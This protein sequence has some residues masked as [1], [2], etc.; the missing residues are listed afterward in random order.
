MDIAFK[1]NSKAPYFLLSNFYGGSEFTYMS[2]RTENVNLKKL[3][4]KL[5]DNL[6][7]DTFKIYRERLMGKKIYKEGYKDAYVKTYNGKEYYGFGL[8]AKLIS[9]CYKTSMKKRLKV[10]NEIAKEIHIE[11]NITQKDFI[12]G[13]EYEN[14][15]YMKIALQL[16]FQNEPYKTVLMETYPMKLYERQGNRGMSLWAG[17]DGWLGTL[18]MEIRE[19]LKSTVLGKRIR[20]QLKF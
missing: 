4:I 13:K 2:Q 20:L 15:G 6:D 14:I 1:S 3:Y 8:I 10:V 9:A 17:K 19:E 5:R 16:K 7:Y 18:L 12:G 11:G